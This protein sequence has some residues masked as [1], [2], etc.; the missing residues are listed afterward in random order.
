MKKLKII[1]MTPFFFPVQGGMEIHVFETSKML[2]KLGYGVEVFSSNKLRKGK[3]KNKTDMY[4]GIPVRRFNSLFHV[5]KLAPIWPGVLFRIMFEK[6]DILHMHSYRHQH[7]LC[8]LIAKLRRKKVIL[9]PHWPEY[10]MELRN[11]I[12]RNIIPLFDKVLGKLIF[13]SCDM[14]FADTGSEKKWL[15]KRFNINSNK[16][17]VI[18]PGISKTEFR[19]V[20]SE[21]FKKKYKIGKNKL[22]VS[23]G[24]LHRS[25]GHEQI[26]KIA[27]KFPNTK[28][29]FVGNDG[30]EKKY[31]VKLIKKLNAKNVIIAE[32]VPDSE[33]PKALKAADVF[34]SGTQ[35]EGFGIM[36]AEAMAQGTPVV[37]TDVAAVSWVIKGCGYT[38]KNHDSK[39]LENKLRNILNNPKLKKELGNNALKR[40]KLFTFDNIIKELKKSYKELLRG[41]KRE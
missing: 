13:A 30:G 20:N 10:P 24:R 3:I 2:K 23:V 38:F 26:V 4:D 21:S 39:D 6:F 25:K 11:K 7:N 16:I 28:F 40:A 8:G 1:Q 37:A 35:Y 5:T 32:N 27:N 36:F 12:V 18:T 41:N 22:V 9:T 29:V 33:R 31:L 34:C 19:K 17:K 14:I 15:I